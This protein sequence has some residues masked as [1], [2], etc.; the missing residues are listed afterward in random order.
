MTGESLST[1]HRTETRPPPENLP[2]PTLLVAHAGLIPYFK[3]GKA[4]RFRV[5]DVSRAC[6]CL[7]Y[8][9]ITPSLPKMPSSSHPKGRLPWTRFWSPRKTRD[10]GICGE[11]FEHTQSFFGEH[12][13]PKAVPLSEITPETGLLVL[14]G[15]PGLGKTTE[16]DLLRELL[17]AEAQGDRLLIHVQ[18]R[19]FDS[20]PIS[21]GI[22]KTTLLGRHGS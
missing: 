20:F 14:C 6:I 15:E 13:H 17:S 7:R 16:L 9:S 4:V 1:A 2:P 18:A 5:A 12:L 11:F 8:F 19:E 22:W 3:L 21:K 10:H